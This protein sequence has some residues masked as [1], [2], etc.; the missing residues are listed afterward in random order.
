MISSERLSLVAL[1]TGP[2]GS[3]KTLLMT[4]Y[5]CQRLIKAHF[6]KH[7]RGIDQSVWS[8]YPVRFFFR[9]PICNKVERLE[10]K[11]LNMESF[12]TFDDELS[13]G[14]VFIDEIDQ[15]LDRQDWAAVTQKLISKVLTQIRKKQLSLFG[16]LQDAE[17]LNS[18]CFFQVDL[19]TNCREAAFS[20]W[21]KK[22][23]LDLG[24]AGFT[25]WIDKSGIITGYMYKETGRIYP[26]T[27]WGKRFWNCYDTNYVFDPL[28]SRTKYRIKAPTKV[29][30][31]GQG[32]NLDALDPLKSQKYDPN[33]VIL[34]DIIYE[35]K[36]KK[37][38][39]ITKSELWKMAYA[40]GFIGD[41]GTAGRFITK[42]L[43]IEAHSDKYLLQVG[44][45]G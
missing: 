32:D 38:S 5:I 20:P 21:G 28:E 14:W 10:S 16:T 19:V 9:C 29:I 23:G 8:N 17:W 37:V 11:P 22:M 12:Y 40:K 7:L 25:S 41:L 44:G 39:K 15:W 31:I 3:Q 4:S 36:E 45:G 18:R 33:Q 26:C 27:F 35:L 1:A 30:E 6:Y 13:K 24:E 34:S 2:R 43:G 42:I